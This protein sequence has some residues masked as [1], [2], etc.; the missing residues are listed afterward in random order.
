LVRESLSQRA[1]AEARFRF[2]R[3]ALG[4]ARPNDLQAIEK[5]LARWGILNDM[6]RETLLD[7]I[8]GPLCARLQVEPPASADRLGF[9]EDLL[10]AEY[11]RQG[12]RLG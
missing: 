2:D 1:P 7:Q 5:I 3:A 11:R 12:R 10:A 6:E 4:R 9:L 8:I